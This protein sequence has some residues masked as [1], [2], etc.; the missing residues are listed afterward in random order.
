MDVS[1]DGWLSRRVCLLM[2]VYAERG[3]AGYLVR[4]QAGSSIHSVG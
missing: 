2:Q 4:P 3:W 1:G